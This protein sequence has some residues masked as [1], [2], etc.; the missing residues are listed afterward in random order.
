MGKVR[1]GGGGAPQEGWDW[2]QH[3][4]LFHQSSM[5]D[6][7]AQ[8]RSHQIAGGDWSS[9]IARPTIFWGGRGGEETLVAAAA[10]AG[11]N[12][13]HFYPTASIGDQ[14]LKIGL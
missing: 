5:L 7:E 12:S 8:H 13:A 14:Q 9:L 6:L 4:L 11:I 3:T 1:L 10:P 2:W